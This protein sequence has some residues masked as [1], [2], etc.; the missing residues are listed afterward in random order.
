MRRIPVICLA[1]L[2]GL[3]FMDNSYA[4]EVR[5]MK[6]VMIIASSDFRDEELFETKAVLE[7]EG[8]EVTIASSSLS[9]SR[10]MLGG[11]A[12]PE[13]LLND[14]KVADYDGVVFVGGIGA[15][16]YWDS[17]VAHNIAKDA[18]SFDKVL[19]A[20]CIAPVTLAN[21]GV[22]RNK[23]ATVWGSEGGKLRSKGAVYTK[24]NVEVDGKIVT[25]DGP[26]SARQ[27]GE[28]ILDLLKR[29]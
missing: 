26:T 4:Q 5:G 7:N 3:G 1:M 20:I 14:V 21:S 18:V 9:P 23:R 22:L 27:F 24:K 10:G 11:K 8:V 6:V 16:E 19:G 25:A 12:K 17:A 2:M 28:S 13:V 15:Q 29:K